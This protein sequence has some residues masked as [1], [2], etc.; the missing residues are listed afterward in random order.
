MW[1]LIALKYQLSLCAANNCSESWV[2]TASSSS[3]WQERRT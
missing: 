1:H 2:T 3:T